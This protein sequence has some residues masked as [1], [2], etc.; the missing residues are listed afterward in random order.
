MLRIAF[1]FLNISVLPRD[2]RQSISI[3]LIRLPLYVNGIIA[4]MVRHI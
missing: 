4:Q 2:I 1:I 3:W